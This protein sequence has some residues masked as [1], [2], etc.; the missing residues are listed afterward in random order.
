MG[1]L[2]ATIMSHLASAAELPLYV[3]ASAPG[4]EIRRIVKV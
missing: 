2:P 1:C 4:P 3:T